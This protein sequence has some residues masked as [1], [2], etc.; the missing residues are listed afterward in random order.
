MEKMYLERA[1]CTADNLCT[2]KVDVVIVCHLPLLRSHHSLNRFSLAYAIYLSVYIC[3]SLAILL[4]PV[5]LRQ[6][7]YVG[8]TDPVS[9]HRLRLFQCLDLCTL[10]PFSILIYSSCFDSP[11]SFPLYPFSK[12]SFS[13]YIHSCIVFPSF[14]FGS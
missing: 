7:V 8:H 11:T 1:L 4:D 6:K 9:I 12:C 5:T 10:P 14:L 13:P 3:N 2:S